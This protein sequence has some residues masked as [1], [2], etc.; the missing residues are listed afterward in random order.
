MCR[1]WLFF[2]CLTLSAQAP[3]GIRFEQEPAANSPDSGEGRY[4]LVIGISNHLHLP[5]EAQLRFAHRDA[6]ELAAFLRSSRG[7]MIP[8]S[9]IR[10]LTNEQATLAAIRGALHN[11]LPGSARPTD[12][13]YV[14]FAGHGVLAERDEGYFV[15]YDSDPQNLHA[16][17]LPFAE[18][19][20]SL[21]EDL[22]SSLVVLMIDA[23][24]SGSLGWSSY[25]ATQPSKA[26]E[27]IA[28][29]GHGDRSFLKLL[30]SRPSEQS[31]EDERWDGGHGIF[32]FAMLQGLT[33]GADRDNDRI[34]RASELSDYISSVV[35][36][37]TQARQHPRVAGTFDARMV[38]ANVP[39]VAATTP[40]TGN[41]EISGPAGAEIYIDSAF[42]G[43]VRHDGR[44][45][46]D[47]IAFGP[48]R[49]SADIEPGKTLEGK[50]TVSASASL[51][52]I[53]QIPATP[54]SQ[55][56][57][58]I[59]SG[60]ILE[61][62]G[63]WDFYRAQNFPGTQHAAASAFLGA[64]LE[65][66][67]QACVSDYV[68]STEIGPKK[69]MLRR[70]SAAYERLRVLRPNDPGLE[71]RALFCQARLQIAD[72][73]FESALV[74][75]RQ[76]LKIDSQF[77][78]A[79]N[80]MGV[81]LG[82][83][84]RF[85]ESRRAFETAARLT[86]EWALPPF[87]IA[88]QLM[89]NGEVRQAVPYLEQASRYNPRSVIPRWT[90]MRAHRLL[91]GLSDVERDATELT[92]LN[93]NYAPTYLELGRAYEAAGRSANAT[94]AYETYL[95]LA[96]NYADSDEIRRRVQRNKAQPARP[97][98]TLRRTGER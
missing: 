70:A 18:V 48:H 90:L 29:L 11:W 85:Q 55:L 80:A 79:Y 49:L 64:A 89:A 2:V 9:H 32:T 12:I 58:R 88:S 17:A 74:T 68:Q 54:L 95:L 97:N 45:M 19:D 83:L 22:R 71:A 67:G 26:A 65:E 51:M 40:A 27:S 36:S 94:E 78:C 23:C 42:R 35:P 10:L 81:V 5:P 86:P 96:P 46:I 30:A 25:S 44:L 8:A 47:S 61:T 92:R 98:P 53:P 13:V 84:N 72:S 52:K 33:G 56:L 24:H 15:A 62:A 41:L 7:G 63:A 93:P 39:G 20:R 4:A 43:S 77:A 14:F 50:F 75:L 59:A 38:L 87:Q 57:R 37:Q 3:R 21:S 60:Q 66:L 6:E 73:Q 76:S 82:R 91:G 31:F 34:I 69:A 16:T 28:A 1:Y